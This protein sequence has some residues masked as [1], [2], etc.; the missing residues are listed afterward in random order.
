[1]L[2]GIAIV[3][4]FNTFL[5]A[6]LTFIIAAAY[7]LHPYPLELELVREF[8]LIPKAEFEVGHVERDGR[9]GKMI[10]ISYVRKTPHE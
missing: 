1:M 9:E 3:L 7:W 10:Y 4:A 5:L 2:I 6:F 8:H